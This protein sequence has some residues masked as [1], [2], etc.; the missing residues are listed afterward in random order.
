MAVDQPEPEPEPEPEPPTDFPFHLDT[1]LVKAVFDF[2]KMTLTVEENTPIWE[3]LSGLIFD[4]E[5]VGVLFFDAEGTPITDDSVILQE[6]MTMIVQPVSYTH[7]DVY[8]RQSLH[9]H[10]CRTSL[11]TST[12]QFLL[13]SMVRLYHKNVC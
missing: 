4:E 7:L 9:F 10:S 6:G 12:F 5:N 13:W 3:L 2:D 1:S 8:K 11:I